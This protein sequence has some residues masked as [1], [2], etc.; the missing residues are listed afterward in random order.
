MSRN[1][2][3]DSI[4][5]FVIVG[6]RQESDEYNEA[7]EGEKGFYVIVSPKALKDKRIGPNDKVLFYGTAQ[8]RRDIGRIM[9]ELE[10]ARTR[11]N[12]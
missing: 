8:S 12:Q 6:N 5:K 2:G 3:A 9:K 4:T 11:G 7:H 1:E 10:N